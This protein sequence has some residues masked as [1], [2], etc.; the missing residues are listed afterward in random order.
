MNANTDSE[1]PICLLDIDLDTKFVTQCNHEYHR[2]CLSAVRDGKCPMCRRRIDVPSGE[3]QAAIGMVV[4][5]DICC[6]IHGI[7]RPAQNRPHNSFRQYEVFLLYDQLV[8]NFRGSEE[9]V[10]EMNDPDVTSVYR[11]TTPYELRQRAIERRDAN[12]RR[13]RAYEI[14]HPEVVQPQMRAAAYLHAEIML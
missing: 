12:L 9:Y 8:D 1:C 6:P 14:S 10:Q 5:C 7:N 4:A 3:Q 2:E 11:Y 13:V